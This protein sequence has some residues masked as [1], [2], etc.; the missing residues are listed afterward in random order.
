MLGQI[1]QNPLAQLGLSA[2]FLAATLVVFP[3]FC[4]GC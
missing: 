4:L 2:G 3:K 1:L